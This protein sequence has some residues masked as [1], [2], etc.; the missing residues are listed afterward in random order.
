LVRA[1]LITVEQMNE[2][3]ARQTKEGGRFGDH[4]VALGHMS[5]E[6]LDAFIHKTPVEPETVEATGLDEN[7]LVSLLM[8][9]IYTW[10]L[11]SVREFSDAIKLPGHLVMKLIRMA[12]D[13]KLLYAR[14]VRPDNAAAMN[15]AMTDEGQRWAMDALQR[16]QYTGPAPITL[17][18]YIERVN[19]QKITN[20]VITFQRVRNNISDL[21]ME[22]KLIEQSGPALNSGR[23]ILLYGPPGNGKTTFALRLANVFTDMIYIPYAVTVEGQIIRVFDPSIHVPI[24]PNETT[25][26]GAPSILKGEAVD[27]R[28]IACKRPF[29]VAGGELTLEMLD[30]RYDATSKFYEAPL[31]MKALGGCFVIDDFGRQLVTPTTL[32]NRWIV[33]LESRIDFLKLHTGKSFSIPFDELVIFSTNL[34]PEDLM[35]PAFL[36]RLPYKIEI[37]SPSVELYRSI[38][39]KECKA[40]K[41]ELT[42]FAFEEIVYKIRE[43]KQ[44]E[45][46]AFQPRF[47][48][49]QVAASCRFMEQP[50]TLEP[51]FLNYAIDNLR[52]QPSASGV[53]ASGFRKTSA[54]V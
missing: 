15:Y 9:L 43:E 14:G 41:I 5:Q 39:E 11:E 47:L 31:H 10:R 37:G 21:A 3:L 42:D 1:K 12:T 36:R 22:N 50:P 26:L 2:A 35:D 51:R 19:L 54:L 33:P 23:A 4:L 45:L 44:L 7:E 28:W 13:R 49:E 18:E 20:E 53:D 38:F 25:E 34:E 6:K 52:V 17:E 48:L 32:L 30:L 24:K 8:K 40:L 46:A 27:A 16:S 29:V